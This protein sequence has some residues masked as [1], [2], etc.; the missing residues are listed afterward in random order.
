MIDQVDRRLK[1]W[2]GGVLDPVEVHLEAPKVT[3]QCRGVSLYLFQ[4]GPMPAPSTSKLPP[5]QLAL[6]YL[7]TA[8]SDDLEEAHRM[9]GELV[10]AAMGTPEFQVDLGALPA[11]TWRALGVPPRPSFVLCLPLR[12][13]RTEAPAKL[14]RSAPVV[15]TAAM[16]GLHGVVLGPNDVALAGAEV[17]I[18]A[19]RLARRT[20]HYGRF[21]FTAVPG[22]GQRK[23]LRVKFK[24]LEQ[25]VTTEEDFLDPNKP[26]V[27]RFGNLEA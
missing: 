10:F 5:L 21:Y 23:T 27:I 22:E 2:I 17:Q 4:L 15:Q 9:L 26:L 7:V 16:V 3:G 1:D 6:R 8:W 24:S 18:E 20:G 14:V 12:R 25:S 11:E 13:A 19:L